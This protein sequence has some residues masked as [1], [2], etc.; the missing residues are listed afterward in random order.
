M[1]TMWVYRAFV[2]DDDDD[3]M[4]GQ[5]D[6]F[7]KGIFG[8]QRL[9]WY[10]FDTA[11][12]AVYDS[13]NKLENRIDVPLL[14]KAKDV[15]S[16][17]GRLLWST[18]D[19]IAAYYRYCLRA[20]EKPVLALD[21]ELWRQISSKQYIAY[22]YEEVRELCRD[23]KFAR[24]VVIAV[25]DGYEKSAH[26]ARLNIQDVLDMRYGF[27]Y[28][29]SRRDTERLFKKELGYVYVMA[30]PSM[31]GLLKIGMTSRDPSLRANEVSSSTGV[32][33]KF[34]VIHS[35]WALNC[36]V[37]EEAIHQELES[38]RYSPNREFF[39]L[40]VKDAINT[41]DRIVDDINRCVAA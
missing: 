39:C 11:R 4:W 28:W 6:A 36:R 5:F 22:F 13:K 26:Q 19:A 16:F 41:V 1:Y 30:N 24:E 3:L 32:P 34:V 15:E 31:D 21:S 38:Y 10:L 18:C 12:Q 23:I 27:G 14:A 17:E 20:T 25:V 2:G 9:A 37:A 7:T 33:H 40:P 35:V 29:S 8:E